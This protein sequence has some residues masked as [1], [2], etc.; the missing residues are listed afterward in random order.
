MLDYRR[1]AIDLAKHYRNNQTKIELLRKSSRR[2]IQ[3]Y[4]EFAVR[5]GLNQILYIEDEENAVLMDLTKDTEK[6]LKVQSILG[7]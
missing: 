6:V 5:N 1:V 3:E 4:R 2:S 7:E